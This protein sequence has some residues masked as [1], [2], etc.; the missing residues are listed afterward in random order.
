MKAIYTVTGKSCMNLGFWL[1][2]APA[3]QSHGP[4]VTARLEQQPL[5]QLLGGTGDAQRAQ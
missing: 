3:L 2:N 5:R 1:G 4:A